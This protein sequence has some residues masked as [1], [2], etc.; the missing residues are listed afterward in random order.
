MSLPTHSTGRA[1]RRIRRPG[2][3]KGRQARLRAKER[4]QSIVFREER[5]RGLLDAAATRRRRRARLSPL[6]SLRLASLTL[7]MMEPAAVFVIRSL[8]MTCDRA[9]PSRGRRGVR[10]S[11]KG[12]RERERRGAPHASPAAR[13]RARRQRRRPRALRPHRRRPRRPPPRPRRPRPRARTTMVPVLLLLLWG[14]QQLSTLAQRSRDPPA[15]PPSRRG[16][17]PARAR[18]VSLFFFFCVLCL[19]GGSTPWGVC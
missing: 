7:P 13:P 14:Q 5:R 2:A 4:E 16:R 8:Q 12:S 6:P 18:R 9:A 3:E 10:Q 15:R 17:S 1:A 19:K 11:L